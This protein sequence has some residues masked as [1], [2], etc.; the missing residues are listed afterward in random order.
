MTD[1]NFVR[2]HIRRH[3]IVLAT[4]FVFRRIKPCIL[5]TRGYSIWRSWGMRWR[6]GT[7]GENWPCQSLELY[8]LSWRHKVIRW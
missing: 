7:C 4:P 3:E 1:R 8:E 6:F 2:E 5:I